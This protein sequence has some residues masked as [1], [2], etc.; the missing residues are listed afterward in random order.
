[1]TDALQVLG[2]AARLRRRMNVYQFSRRSPAGLA[3]VLST[4]A[5]PVG[6]ALLAGLLLVRLDVAPALATATWISTG[7]MVTPEGEGTATLLP[8]GKVLVAGGYSYNGGTFAS[9]QLYDPPTKMWS[10]TGSMSTR[11]GQDTATLL[12]NGKVLVAGGYAPESGITAS[13]ELY[14]PGTGTWS[15]TGSM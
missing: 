12:G 6:V 14:D 5:W 2:A 7:A 1:M 15:A 3:R 10:L 9:A 11:R 8:T 4:V 13:A